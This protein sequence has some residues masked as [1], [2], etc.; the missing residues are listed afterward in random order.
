MVR[1]KELGKGAPINP[2]RYYIWTWV[3]YTRNRFL[4]EKHY[5]RKR[6]TCIPYFTRYHAKKTI[7][8]YYGTQVMNAIHIIAGRNLIKKGIHYYYEMDPLNRSKKGASRFWFEGELLKARKFFIP[9]NYKVD[10]HRRRH[11][12]VAMHQAY[13]NHGKKAFDQK[14]ARYLYG[15]RQGISKQYTRKTRFKIRDTILPG[16]QEDLR[17]REGNL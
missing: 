8:M 9:D 15:S 12:M 13:K 2:D 5:F 1:I 10:K 3:P 4:T 16:V 6:L 11:F 17:R 14:Y 7:Q